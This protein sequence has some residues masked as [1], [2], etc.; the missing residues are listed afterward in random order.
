MLKTLM[1]GID[2][3]K[4]IFHVYIMPPMHARNL[5]HYTTHVITGV[6]EVKIFRKMGE[7]GNVQTVS[8]LSTFMLTSQSLGTRLA[9]SKDFIFSLFS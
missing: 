3:V 6:H 7:P 4:G 5:R 8:V 9:D 2:F 1:C